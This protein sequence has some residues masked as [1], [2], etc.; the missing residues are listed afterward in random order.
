MIDIP[1]E[2]YEYIVNGKS[3][4]EWVMTRQS[5]SVDKDSKIKNDAN[6]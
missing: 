4:L 5:V 3:A 2:A 1:L 6:D